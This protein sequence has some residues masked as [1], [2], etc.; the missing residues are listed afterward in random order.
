M[1][2]SFFLHVMELSNR[3][4]LFWDAVDKGLLIEFEVKKNKK[5]QEYREK[6]SC[7]DAILPTKIEKNISCQQRRNRHTVMKTAQKMG[8]KKQSL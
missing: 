6:T 1:E 2:N 4:Q 3:Y 8:I 7:L 5:N